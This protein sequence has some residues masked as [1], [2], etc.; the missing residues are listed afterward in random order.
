M[1]W[2]V[3]IEN[4]RLKEIAPWYIQLNDDPSKYIVTVKATLRPFK[5]GTFVLLDYGLDAPEYRRLGIIQSRH[6]PP[7]AVK[8]A[9]EKFWQTLTKIS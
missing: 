4:P 3:E 7:A 1:A 2:V 6:A 5:D 9:A 8:V